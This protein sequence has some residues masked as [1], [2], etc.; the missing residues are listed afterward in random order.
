MP[1]S[2]KDKEFAAQIMIA[3]IQHAK[4]NPFSTALAE[5]VRFE[6]IWHRIVEAISKS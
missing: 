5:D 2:D 6:A 1:A 4:L 3:Y